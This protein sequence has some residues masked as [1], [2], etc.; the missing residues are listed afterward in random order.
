M[1]EGRGDDEWAF[2]A[3][4][5]A[6]LYNLTRD[7]SERGG[8]P[9]ASWEFNPYHEGPP[10]VPAVDGYLDADDLALVFGHRNRR[11]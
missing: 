6:E 2:R 1:A 9:F 8:E 4:V 11:S 7:L 10:P 3:S 5:L